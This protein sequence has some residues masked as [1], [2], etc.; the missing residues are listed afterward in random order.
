MCDFDKDSIIAKMNRDHFAIDVVG[1]EIVDVSAGAA[2]VRLVV[3][4]RHLNGVGITQGGVLFT[5]A[6]YAFAIA[7]NTV[8]GQVAVGIE[9]NMSYM[10]PSK[11]GAVLVCEARETSRTRSLAS[12]E[13]TVTDSS[14]GKTLARF[15]GRAFVKELQREVKEG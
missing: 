4:E 8:A 11:V 15:Y 2:S 1:I 3:G 14:T 5:L 6:D 10:S 9:C 13:A 7:T 12:V